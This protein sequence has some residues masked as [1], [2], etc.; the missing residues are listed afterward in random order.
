MQIRIRET[1][2]VVSEQGFRVMHPNTS[3]PQQLTE[4]TINDLGGDVVFEGPQ[5]QPTR[6]QIGFADGV[7]QK[8]DGKWYTK[9]SVADMNAEA[10]AATDAE[11][12]K[13]VRAERNRRL[14]AL[15]WTQGKDIPDSISSP[16]ALARQGL[17]DVP[18]QAGF[19]WEIT[20][21]DAE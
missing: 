20:W 14:S 2:A 9:Y 16:A 7:E 3:M 13:S 6:Y 5:A 21:P 19:P 10:I 8:S 4:T 15:D 1:G 12:A 18:N 11:Q 17:R